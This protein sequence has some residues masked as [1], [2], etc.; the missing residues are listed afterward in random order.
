MDINKDIDEVE[1]PYVCP[2]GTCPRGTV[3]VNCVPCHKNA[4][5]TCS[6]CDNVLHPDDDIPEQIYCRYCI[7]ENEDDD[8]YASIRW[9]EIQADDDEQHRLFELKCD[10]IIK[11][12]K[13]DKK[14]EYEKDFDEYEKCMKAYNLARR[15]L[16]ENEIFQRKLYLDEV[17]ID[18]QGEEQIIIYSRIN[19]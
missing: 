17:N 14:K 4:W 6:N 18:E 10:L 9:A 2:H 15:K 1:E 3:S 5:P 13:E 19:K 16:W 7:H 12:K 11:Q 8:E